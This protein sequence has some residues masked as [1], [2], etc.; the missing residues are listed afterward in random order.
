MWLHQAW[1]GDIAAVGYYM[2]KGESPKQ[3]SYWWPEDGRG[4]IGNDTFAVLKGAPHPVLAHLFLDHMLDL[5][6]AFLNFEFTL[7][8]QPLNG[9]TPERVLESE[10]VPANLETTILREPQF[11]RGYVQGPL[12]AEA[13]GL[14]ETAWSEVKST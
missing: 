4:L 13:L 9:M 7:Y 10:L 14:W 12:S 8:Q 6:E 3:V 1:S 2:P 11:R 5:E